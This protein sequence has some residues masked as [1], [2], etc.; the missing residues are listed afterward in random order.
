[1]IDGA[2]KFKVDISKTLMVMAMVQVPCL[3]ENSYTDLGVL[4]RHHPCI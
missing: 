4:V 3:T 1:M 2:Q